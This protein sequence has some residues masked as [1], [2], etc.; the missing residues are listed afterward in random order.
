MAFTDPAPRLRGYV[1]ERF[2]RD[3]CGYWPG[4][5]IPAKGRFANDGA[6]VVV[7]L[8]PLASDQRDTRTLMEGGDRRHPR[9]RLRALE[10]VEERALGGRLAGTL[11]VTG[12]ITAS[13]MLLLPGVETSHWRLVLSLAGIGLAWALA[14]FFLIPWE[15]ASPLV[16]HFSCAL[17]F[18]ITAIAV[19]ATGG[20]SSP[21]VF[22]LLFIVGY[23]AYFYRRRE[24]IPYLFACIA[25]H[26]LPLFYDANAVDEGLVAQLLIL[27]PTYLL[28][29]GLIIVGKERLVEL[30]DE[31]RR[32]SLADPLTGLANRRALIDLLEAST[33]GGR[34]KDPVG[35]VLVDLD[36]FKEANT[37]YGHPGGDT[38]LIAAAGALQSAARSEDMVSRLG[39]DEFAIVARGLSADGLDALAVRVLSAVREAGTRLVG[40]PAYALRCSVGCA[41]YPDDARDVD[42]LVATADLCMR[43]AKATGKDR[44]LSTRDFAIDPVAVA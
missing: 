37:M 3:G 6:L 23:C 7:K 41:L 43:G 36:G 20:A 1:T 27:G 11:Y 24:A 21:A 38:A 18:P 40:M 22:Y 35:L 17:G 14:C 9:P 25:V 31:A 44:S 16:S 29:G 10:M 5:R 42:E 19:A 39:G 28:L 8:R 32:L 15:R 13:S 30:R 2:L 34:A 12:A 26:S 33:A 4:A